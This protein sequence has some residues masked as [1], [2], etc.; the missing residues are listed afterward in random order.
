[1]CGIAGFAVAGD[2]PGARAILERYQLRPE[3][4]L[5]VGNSLRSDIL[6]VLQIGGKAVLIPYAN[7]WAHEMQ[8][9]DNQDGGYVTLPSLSHLPAYLEKG[10]IS[11]SSV[12]NYLE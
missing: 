3:R 10:V 5:M 7:T 12:D 4:F 2:D 6:P 9:G 11:L 1:M 8:V